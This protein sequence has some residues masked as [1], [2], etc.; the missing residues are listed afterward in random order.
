MIANSEIRL[1]HRCRE[2]V[3][4]AIIAVVL[5]ASLSAE[6]KAT[7]E[8]V[9]WA[10]RPLIHPQIPQV[11]NLQWIRTDIDRFILARQEAV[12]L[13]PNPQID[14]RGLV[15]RVYF[16]LTGLPPTPQEIDAFVS[17]PSPTAYEELVSKLLDSPRYGERW[18]RHWLD[19]AR[20]ADSKGYRYDDNTTWAWTYR[21]FVIRAV[22]QDIPFD[23]FL[24]WQ[25]A[26]DELAPGNPDALAATGFCAIGPIE[27]DEGTKRNKLENRYNELDDIVSTVGSSALALTIGCARCHDHKFDPI[28][29]REYYA[30]VGAFMAGARRELE[31][32]TPEERL[33]LDEWNAKLGK[34]DILVNEW[35]QRHADSLSPVI[36]KHAAPLEQTLIEME[37][38]FRD[39]I[40]RL[41]DNVEGTFEEMLKEYGEQLLGR[42]KLKKFRDTQKS[43]KA[44]PEALLA[45]VS[46][47]NDRIPD[48][49]LAEIREL[50]QQRQAMESERPVSPPKVQAYVDISNTPVPS[51]LLDFGSI[52]APQEVVGFDVLHVLTQTGAVPVPQPGVKST[53]QRA[54]L[55]KWL[56]DPHEGA[57]FLVARVMANRLWYHHF[58]E[59]LVR[60][61]NDF[62]TQG[63]TPEIPEL[64]DWLASQLIEKKWS[65][66]EMHR[67]ILLS[68]VYQQNDTHDAQRF[69]IDPE[70]RLWWKRRP[71]RLEAEILRDSM[72]SVS[73]RLVL[74]MG[75]P[76]DFQPV[77]PEAI[78]SRLGQAYPQDIADGPDVWRRSVYA[79][80]K[81]TVPAPIFQTFDGPDNSSSCG[82]RT[83]T[84]VSPQALLLMNDEFVRRR[85][86][87]FARRITSDHPHD[88]GARVNQAFQL[89]LGRDPSSDERAKALNF[90]VAQ[91]ERHSG[92][93]ALA[94]NDFCQ[95]LFGL[96]EFLYV[97]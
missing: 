34:V 22:N 52:D 45:D 70:N 41:P 26:G 88:A 95:V 68:A 20:Y 97:D 42:A 92:D 75:G 59:G 38:D 39:K 81:R 9:H 96:S 6:E 62:G 48:E 93:E 12:G 21:D 44:L 13:E 94:L 33:K 55:A 32:L 89:A 43:L 72:L 16:D 73:G 71:L 85:S 24:R 67:L 30:L 49:A 82:R 1:A 63:D 2:G 36:E 80:I 77:P 4:F 25:I 8:E 61:P 19:L 69:A 57:G 53:G 65:L 11:K 64:L 58:G 76:G 37:K 91:A 17:D 47:W 3:L 84:T 40:A 51:P 60:T 14:A 66:K 10:F 86:A 18:G 15:R 56:T 50:Q 35:R 46:L 5:A 87:D 29:Q 78:L 23:R 28:L 54:A 27:R 90:L 74:Q 83:L 79:F 7:S 31:I